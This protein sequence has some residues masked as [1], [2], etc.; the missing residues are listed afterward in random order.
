[1]PLLLRGQVGAY[2]SALL[3]GG[4]FMAVVASAAAF[5]CKAAP[6]PSWTNAIGAMTIAFGLGQCIGPV[7]SGLLSDGL[8]DV[9]T[10]LWVSWC[11]LRGEVVVAAWQ[12]EPRREANSMM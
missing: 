9:G 7:L 1:M 5:A 10:G 12:P 8:D 11:I 4:S 3:F 6:P 2:V